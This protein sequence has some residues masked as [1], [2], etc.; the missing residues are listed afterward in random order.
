MAPRP[1]KPYFAEIDKAK[2]ES[3]LLE[4]AKRLVK[5]RLQALIGGDGQGSGAGT[6][7]EAHR[8]EEAAQGQAAS[9]RSGRLRANLFE[10]LRKSLEADAPSTRKRS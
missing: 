5:E 6:P 8:A 1:I 7:A 9:R 3:E 2:P 10:T 4:L